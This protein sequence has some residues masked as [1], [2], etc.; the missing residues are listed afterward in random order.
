MKRL[1]EEALEE[2]I[3]FYIHLCVCAQMYKNFL[4]K[5]LLFIFQKLMK[6]AMMKVIFLLNNMF[7]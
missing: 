1:E 2:V 7:L 5:M 3:N 6:M 4:H